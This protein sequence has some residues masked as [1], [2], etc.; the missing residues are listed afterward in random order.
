MR[1]LRSSRL[2]RAAL[3]L[4]LLLPG[5]SD[6][7][8]QASPTPTAVTYD[9][10]KQS[11]ERMLTQAERIRGQLDA[12]QF[13]LDALSAKLGVNADDIVKYVRDNIAFEQYPGLLRGAKW[14]LIGRAGNSIDEAAL[15][16]TLLTKAGYQV[17]VE[18]GALNPEQAT[19]LLLQMQVPRKDVPPIGNLDAIKTLMK[20]LAKTA[21][22]SDA[23]LQPYLDGLGKTT[24]VSASDTTALESDAASIAATLDAAGVK[25]GDSMSLANLATEASDYF[26][27][28]YRKTIDDKWTDAHPAFKDGAD[29]PVVTPTESF[30]TVAAIPAAEIQTVKI[31][32]ILERSIDGQISQKSLA[33]PIEIPAYQLAD[34]ALF[35]S[36][37]SNAAAALKVPNVNPGDLLAAANLFL[38]QFNNHVTDNTSV[39]FDLNGSIFNLKELKP[40]EFGVEPSTGEVVSNAIAGAIS[41]LDDSPTPTPGPVHVLHLTGVWINLT[42]TSP[43]KNATT[44]RRMIVDRIGAANRAAGKTDL[45]DPNDA[46]SVAAALAQHVSI[47]AAV[48]ATSTAYVANQVYD[49]LSRLA[50]LVLMKL[51]STYFPDETFTLTSAQRDSVGTAWPGFLTL[52]AAFDAAS[53]STPN[54]ISYRPGP[55]VVSYREEFA[56]NGNVPGGWASMVSI[57][58]ISNP[59][60]TYSF[61]NGSVIPAPL[62]TVRAGVWETHSEVV[63]DLDPDQTTSSNTMAVL[64]AAKSQNIPIKVVKSEADLGGIDLAPEALSHLK[65]DLAMG[66]VA[67]IPAKTPQ[68][69]ALTGWWRVDPRT[70]ETLGML[71]N[72]RGTSAVEYITALS[73]YAVCVGLGIFGLSKVV[74]TMMACAFAVMGIFAAGIIANVVAFFLSAAFAAG[75]NRAGFDRPISGGSPEIGFS[76][77][78]IRRPAMPNSDATLHT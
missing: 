27:V 4:L 45:A 12:S 17:K 61:A 5:V 3:A 55:A 50:P 19:S 77:R 58:I 70:G 11:L 38:V 52:Y 33:P 42:F 23:E 32:P 73:V 63:K 66:Y 56:S 64:S 29:A 75:G 57:D 26:W 76:S 54:V 30:A 24:P 72:G 2:L 46:I 16:A 28:S 69:Q 9:Q 10:A 59:R 40:G 71:G 43:G 15:L 67:I 22:M 44:V 31:E 8:A 48:A 74:S 65:D 53:Q 36:T 47:S 35:F 21:G 14:T 37:L 60:R 78:L 25:L 39:V 49:R 62:G 6:V 20:Q 41:A 1:F 13:D 34:Q 51:R 68:G 18:H 7:A